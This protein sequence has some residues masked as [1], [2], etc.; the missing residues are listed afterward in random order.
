MPAT[1]GSQNTRN[2]VDR[3]VHEVEFNTINNGEVFT[4]T[5]PADIPNLNPTYMR[6]TTVTVGDG[7]EPIE[8]AWTADRTPGIAPA[9]ARTLSLRISSRASVTNAVVRVYFEWREQASGGIS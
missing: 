1:I 2:H 5:W 7:G 8:V 4:Y 6:H 3:I 9:T